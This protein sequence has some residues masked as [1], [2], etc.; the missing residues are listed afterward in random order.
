[1]SKFKKGCKPGPGRPKTTP[2]QRAAAFELKRAIALTQAQAWDTIAALAKKK[3]R[4]GLAAAQYVIDRAAGKP[5]Q[6]IQGPNG[7][8][9]TVILNIL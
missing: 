2:E 3:D 1:M 6:T 5:A 8:A 9:P 7:E 4:T